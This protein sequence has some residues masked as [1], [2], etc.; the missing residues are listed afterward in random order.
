MP[1]PELGSDV[2]VIIYVL[3]HPGAVG[4]VSASVD[5]RGAKVVEVK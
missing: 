4:Y 3:R 2:D 5:L 1:P